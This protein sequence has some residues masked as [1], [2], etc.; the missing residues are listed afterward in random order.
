MMSVMEYASDVNKKTDY[1]LEL[2]KKLDIKVN[3]LEDMLTDDDIILL[4][5]EIENTDFDEEESLEEESEKIDDDF[6]DSYVE[7][8]EEVEV[9]ATIKK[10]KNNKSKKDNNNKNE[11]KNE[12]FA[13]QKKEMY[14]HKEKLQSNI[15]TQDDSI[16]LYT[17]GMSVADLANK[18][19]KN[20]AEIIKKLMSLGKIMNLNATIDFETAEILA[21]EYGKTLKKE[22][23]L[24]R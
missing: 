18:L 16:V 23:G 4:D 3:S 14:K 13:K 19:D 7:E 9:E 12:K 22:T 17:E 11:N 24:K 6:E 1:I 15:N 21:L 8:L 5:N 2:C 10:K 20:V